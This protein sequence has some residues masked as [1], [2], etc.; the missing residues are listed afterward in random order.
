[1]L[2][3]YRYFIRI[4]YNGGRYLGWQVQKQT[5]TVQAEVNDALTTI[6]RNPINVVGCGRTD[7]GVHAR[8][9]FAH[10]DVPTPLIADQ[11]PM[12]VKK[13]NG[14]LPW[15]IVVHEL[16]AVTS[17]ANARF[18]ALRRTYKYEIL[19]TKNAFRH[20]YS[21]LYYGT[22]DVDRMNSAAKVLFEYTDFTSFSKVN[23]QVK[24]NNCKIHE[25]LWTKEEDLL[26]FS[27]SAD[28]FLRNMVRA[29]V[30]TLLDVG[31]E[32]LSIRDLRQIIETKDRSAAGYSVPAHGL[33]LHKV[34]YPAA[35]F[36]NS[37]LNRNPIDIK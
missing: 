28:R 34:D 29:I 20:A 30:G 24:T 14:F 36:L 19:S 23:T 35:I 17:E 27:I 26:V 1:M 2:D 12:L 33:Y 18:S 22:L 6:L 3:H 37:D 9:F 31:K 5:P 32:K 10:F 25:A 21:Y 4:S 15:D 13:L 8:H 11:I 7:T 16:L